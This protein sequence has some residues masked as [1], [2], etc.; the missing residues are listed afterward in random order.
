MEVTSS[1][2]NITPNRDESYRVLKREVRTQLQGTTI[3]RRSS[4]Q[5]VDRGSSRRDCAITSATGGQYPGGWAN[6]ESLSGQAQG[7]MVEGVVG[8]GTHFQVSPFRNVERFA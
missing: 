3:L 5:R 8:V 7:R 6:V 1:V 4:S 2:R